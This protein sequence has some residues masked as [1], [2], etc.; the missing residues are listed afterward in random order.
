MS[1]YER[2][3]SVKVYYVENQQNKEIRKF[4]VETQMAG[5]YEY[6]LG[7]VRQVFTDLL[8]KDLEL[9]YQGM[10]CSYIIIYILKY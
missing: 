10:I 6:I 3:V 1:T 9:F 8:R 2:E 4:L 5:N 7:K